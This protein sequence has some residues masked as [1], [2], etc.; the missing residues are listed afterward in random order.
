MS[1]RNWLFIG[2]AIAA[3]GFVMSGRHRTIGAMR[4][5][6]YLHDL[7]GNSHRL[8]EFDGKLLLVNFWAPWCP[9]CRD[10]MP[11][12]DHLR[13]NLADKGFEVVGIG[14]DDPGLIKAYAAAHPVSYPLM[15]NDGPPYS[16]ERIYGNP[17]GILPYSVLIGRNGKV[18]AV[19]AGG[20][21]EAGWNDWL[22]PYL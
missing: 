14:I 4:T 15:L 9:T 18:L 12:L 5:D 22:G 17:K 20:F 2:L 21:N 7:D 1:N 13:A 16:P 11:V 19:Y 3:L 10:E 6:L 8:S